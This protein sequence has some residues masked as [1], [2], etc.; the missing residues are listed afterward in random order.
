MLV[1]CDLSSPRS[2]K[3]YVENEA[4]KHLPYIDTGL[5]LGNMISYAKSIG[6]DS[7]LLNLSEHHFKILRPKKQA[8][9]KMVTLVKVKLGFHKLV[10][11]NLEFCLRRYFQIPAYLKIICG[12]AFGYA[13]KYP[14]VKTEKHGIKRLMRE[15]VDHYIINKE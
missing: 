7:C 14:D 2:Q 13:Q 9:K 10:E 8:I 5:A 6:V 11:E 4:Q 3:M 1:F 15:P 12:V